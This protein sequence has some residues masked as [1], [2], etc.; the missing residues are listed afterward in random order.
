MRRMDASPTSLSGM[1]RDLP[2]LC[3]TPVQVLTSGVHHI[4]ADKSWATC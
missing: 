2:A 3:T 4:I 1:R